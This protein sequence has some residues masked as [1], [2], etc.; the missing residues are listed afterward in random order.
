MAPYKDLEKEENILQIDKNIVELQKT[1]IYFGNKIV[2]E[3][4]TL[5][6]K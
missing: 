4:Q 3:L 5:N 6:Q 2:E 1:I